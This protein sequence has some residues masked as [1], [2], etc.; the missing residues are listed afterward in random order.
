MAQ[1]NAN[2]LEVCEALLA[3]F[4]SDKTH[5]SLR[6][7][8]HVAALQQAISLAKQPAPT[9]YSHVVWAF[10]H[11][12]GRD[13]YLTGPVLAVNARYPRNLILERESDLSC[14]DVNQLAIVHRCDSQADADAWAKANEPPSDPPV[15]AR[16]V[17]DHCERCGLPAQFLDEDGL[18]HA[19][20]VRQDEGSA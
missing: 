18:C 3:D 5:E 12:D 8:P 2:L 15:D 1:P 13:T 19:C 20:L 9:A 6:R 7:G 4:T 11:D 10:P 17:I 16:G 14:H